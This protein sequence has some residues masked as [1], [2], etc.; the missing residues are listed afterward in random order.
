ML[1]NI[2][3][4]QSGDHRRKCNDQEGDTPVTGPQRIPPLFFLSSLWPL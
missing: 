3:R 1:Y 4:L 2:M